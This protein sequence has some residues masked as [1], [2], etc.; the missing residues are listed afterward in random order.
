M[1]FQDHILTDAYCWAFQIS[2]E[3]KMVIANTDR[4]IISSGVY[5]Q[6]S[7]GRRPYVLS[8]QKSI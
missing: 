4:Y 8:T 2:L 3:K 1:G 5:G 6:F 7:N